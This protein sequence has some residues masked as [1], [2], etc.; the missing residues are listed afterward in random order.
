MQTYINPTNALNSD[1]AGLQ[2]GGILAAI[3]GWV[4]ENTADIQAARNLAVGW[5]IWA[6]VDLALYINRRLGGAH[7]SRKAGVYK[8]DLDADVVVWSQVNQGGFPVHVIELKCRSLSSTEAT[9][10]AD[11]ADDR[12]KLTQN[13]LHGAYDDARKWCIGINVG[14]EFTLTSWHKELGPNPVQIY[15]RSFI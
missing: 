11:L 8:A 9:F 13:D 2:G 6:Q 10:K 14:P 4:E 7:A 1:Y 12:F 15:H 3:V 5:E